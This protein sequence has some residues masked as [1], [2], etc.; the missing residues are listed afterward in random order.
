VEDGFVSS[1]SLAVGL[2]MC[3][4]REVGLATQAMEVVRELAGVK[5][6]PAVKEYGARDA[7]AGDDVTPYECTHLSCGDRRDGFCF[8]PLGEVVDHHKEVL[9]LARSRR[10]MGEDVH[11]SCGEREGT[12]YW[13]H[14]GGGDALNGRE[15]LALVAGPYQSHC[16][17]PQTRP[18]VS[19]SYGRNG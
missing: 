8:D 15:L 18:I 10:K 1:L 12:D 17:L 13:C 3:D 6:P 2:G 5:L 16:V 19:G 9:M 4:G 7:K 14:T 11:S